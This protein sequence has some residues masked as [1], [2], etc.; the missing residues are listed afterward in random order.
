MAAVSLAAP[1]DRN[2]PIPP[3]RLKGIVLKGDIVPIIGGNA[4]V[5]VENDSSRAAD[6]DETRGV[7]QS[8]LVSAYGECAVG[9]VEVAPTEVSVEVGDSVQ[10][11]VT[12]E[13]QQG[14]PLAGRKPAWTS[15]NTAVA[16]VDSTGLVRG[17][18]D[19]SAEITM[20]VGG[21]SGNRYPV[22]ETVLPMRASNWVRPPACG[23]HTA[24]ETRPRGNE[25][26]YMRVSTLCTAL[27]VL[28]A[29][30][31]DSPTAPVPGKPLFS[32]QAPPADDCTL[33]P[34]G[35]GGVV[36]VE[37]IPAA[38]TLEMYPPT[39]QGGYVRAK[40]WRDDPN[41]PGVQLNYCRDYHVAP[42][43]TLLNPSIVDWFGG[44][45]TDPQLR[46]VDADAVGTGKV[47][48]ASGALADTTTFTVIQ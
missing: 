9:S 20:R 40:I 28:A 19:G 23:D 1:T 3:E 4:W 37:T 48:A 16:T 5:P 33:F 27:V 26:P 8:S 24:A 17:V 10:L 35:S 46:Y 39:L 38:A 32:H 11:A 21:S 29:C 30:S 45:P 43:W 34:G 31:G 47:K 44:Q 6:A 42:S 18:S 41:T 36:K 7:I 15:S 13:N 22:R 14:N 2:W 12:V 25:R